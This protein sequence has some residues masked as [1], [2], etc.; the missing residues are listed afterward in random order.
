[1]KPKQTPSQSRTSD[2]WRRFGGLFGAEAVT[3]KFGAVP[4]PE[5]VGVMGQLTDY[6]LE[7]GMRRLLHSGKAHVPALPEFRRLC[8]MLADDDLDPPDLPLLSAPAYPGDGWEIASN[9][10]LLSH[11]AHQAKKRV[12]YAGE[13]LTAPLV[14]YKKAWAQDMREGGESPSVAEQKRTWTECMARADAAIDGLREQS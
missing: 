10:H 8:V 9:R 14:A 1:M 12:Y 11:I 13:R 2:L 5:W 6:Q 4:P 3:R 7:R